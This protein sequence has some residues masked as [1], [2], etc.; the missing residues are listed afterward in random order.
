MPSPKWK[1]VVD[2]GEPE[3]SNN[4][5]QAAPVVGES[6]NF[7]QGSVE[8]S[9]NVI[10]LDRSLSGES[11]D[12]R[13]DEVVSLLGEFMPSD[14]SSPLAPYIQGFMSL[15]L[16]LLRPSRS[17][18]D[19]ET[20]RTM[21]ESFTS[22]SQGGR[23]RS[24]I[25]LMLARDFMFLSQA[26]NQQQQFQQ[27]QHPGNFFSFGQGMANSNPSPALPEYASLEDSMSAALA[28]IAV[29]DSISIISN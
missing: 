2:V 5:V 21:L 20:V 19:E 8:L 11:K 17:P 29:G 7:N 10:N 14:P 1:L 3:D 13:I 6:R 24:D 25:G 4:L 26:R 15:R 16:L 28:P 18:E 12:H 22:Y 9:D 23:S 27:Q